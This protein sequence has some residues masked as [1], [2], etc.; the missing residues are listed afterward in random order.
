MK[1][2]KHYWELAAMK[3]DAIARH[4]L[5]IMEHR[6][7]NMDRAVKHYMISV[8]GGY[9]DSLKKI[10]DLYSK[11]HATKEDYTKALQLYQEYLGETKS[12]HRDKAAAAKV[13]YRYY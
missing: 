7:G 5:G 9:P 12:A 3:G 11:G 1:K 10:Q 2:A 6:R 4:N 13:E 8:K